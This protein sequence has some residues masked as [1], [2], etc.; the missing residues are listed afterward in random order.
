MSMKK[1]GTLRRALIRT[2]PVMAGYL[3]L[4]AGFGILLKAKGYGI[5]WAAAMSVFIY[6]GSMQFVAV[7]LICGGAG[8]L[9]V[10]L[11][12]LAV[13]ARHLFYGVSMLDRYRNTGRAKPYLIFSLTDETYSLLSTGPEGETSEYLLVSLLD[14]CW[15]VTGSILGSL[16]GTVIPFNTEGIDFALTALFLTIFL[17]Q[18]R[19]GSHHLPAVLGVGATLLCLLVFGRESFLLPAMGLILISLLFIRKREEGRA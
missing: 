14:Q 2:L 7:D 11:T 18:W 16:I 4:G 15:W 1:K 8:L 5:G 6:A 3:V 9:T 12:T 17:D 10:A 19:E 13:N